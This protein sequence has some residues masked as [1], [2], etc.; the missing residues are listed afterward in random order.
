[1]KRLGESQRYTNLQMERI[2]VINEK[3]FVKGFVYD[4]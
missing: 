2:R 3:Y 1:M 4:K